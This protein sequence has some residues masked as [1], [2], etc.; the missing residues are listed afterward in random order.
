MIISI[1]ED[2]FQKVKQ[3]VK[4]RNQSIYEQLEL[5]KPL[6]AVITDTTL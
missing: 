5:I 4:G 1:N 3:I 2:L 6:E